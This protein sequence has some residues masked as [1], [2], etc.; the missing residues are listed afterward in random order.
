ML[1]TQSCHGLNATHCLLGP[2][3][4]GPPH[5]PLF[6][7]WHAQE[8]GSAR[9]KFEGIPQQ[10]QAAAGGTAAPEPRASLDFA[11]TTEAATAS[12]SRGA[13]KAT[14][15]YQVDGGEAAHAAAIDA[16]PH[17]ITG[18]LV[19]SAK[20]SGICMESGSCSEASPVLGE[21]LS[22]HLHEGVLEVLPLV[23]NAYET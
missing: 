13:G 21:A 16:S 14:G 8:R 12:G 22:L 15:A 18:R 19:C 6:K 10:A 17:D 11:D 2:T 20:G 1:V 5:Q 4:G 7:S 23:R 3:L 9:R